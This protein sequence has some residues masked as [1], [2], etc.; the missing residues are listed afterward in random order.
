MFLF[1]KILTLTLN[2][3][4]VL[5]LYCPPPLIP[6][7]PVDD[8]LVKKPGS[9]TSTDCA[10]FIGWRKVFSYN[11][12]QAKSLS[13]LLSYLCSQVRI[14]CWQCGRPEQ[15]LWWRVPAT[16]LQTVRPGAVQV[17]SWNVFNKWKILLKLKN[18]RIIELEFFLFLIPSPRNA[19]GQFHFKLVYPEIPAT[20]EWF[21]TSNPTT[22]QTITGFQ[23]VS[24]DVTINSHDDAWAG[25]GPGQAW[26][27]WTKIFW[28]W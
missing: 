10:V 11:S 12:R 5:L 8:Q 21:Q 24:L 1:E 3:R 14:L 27:S 15:E 4:Q 23:A 25:L 2:A 17:I 22:E 16:L 7:L 28:K 26:R 19:D 9:S 18:H 6:I 13:K 20:N